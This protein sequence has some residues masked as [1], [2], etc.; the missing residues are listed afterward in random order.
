MC[1]VSLLI[2]WLSIIVGIHNSSLDG[3]DIQTKTSQKPVAI[4]DK[5]VQIG[6]YLTICLHILYFIMNFGP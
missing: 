2:L 3:S 1:L 5:E 4:K 6:N